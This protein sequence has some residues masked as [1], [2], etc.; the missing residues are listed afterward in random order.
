MMHILAFIE[1]LIFIYVEIMQRIQRHFML[2]LRID[3][4]KWWESND[5]G[6]DDDD[7][8]DD[9]DNSY[10]DDVDYNNNVFYCWKSCYYIICIYTFS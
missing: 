9:D 1:S 7:D 2:S 10:D 5:D 8:R 6:D 3:W 4:V